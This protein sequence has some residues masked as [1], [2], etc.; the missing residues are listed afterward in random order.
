MFCQWLWPVA[1]AAAA[2]AAGISSLARLARALERQ[3]NRA[4]CAESAYTIRQIMP[5]Y[6]YRACFTQ[7]LAVSVPPIIADQGYENVRPLS[8][9]AIVSRIVRQMKIDELRKLIEKY[10]HA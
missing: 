9:G 2:A 4:C 8:R 3:I 7:C 5:G 6:I 10:S 1:G